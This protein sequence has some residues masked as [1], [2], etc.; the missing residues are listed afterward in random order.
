MVSVVSRT[1]WVAILTGV[2]AALSGCSI[3]AGVGVSFTPSTSAIQ[4]T[5]GANP[6]A[7]PFILELIGE[8]NDGKRLTVRGRFTPKV[9]WSAA[10]V[11]VRLSALDNAGKA[12]VA[13]FA[14]SNDALSTAFTQLQP[15]MPT[16]FS[17]SIPSVGIT[18]YQLELL[19]GRDAEPHQK[20]ARSLQGAGDEFLALRNLEV[21]RVPSDDCATPNEC[22]VRFT[23]TGEFYNAGSAT[24]S[25][26]QLKAGFVRA[27]ELDLA[28]KVLENER[29]IEVRNMGL[30]PG[31]TKPFRLTLEKFIP[32]DEQVAPKPVV[33]IESFD[34]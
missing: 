2:V 28:D 34:R 22:T 23:L 13:F 9:Q 3:G 12:R 20:Q 31:G 17:V 25:Q 4:T 6:E 5:S 8:V 29:R 32:M 24:I 30:A 33:I 1:A 16:E 19:W 15:G 27:D 10:D 11:L 21:Y 26:V 7:T 14:L 18:N